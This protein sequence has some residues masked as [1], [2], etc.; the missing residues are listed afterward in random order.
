MGQHEE[1]RRI[2]FSAVK[3]AV[4]LP[5]QAEN[6][7]FNAGDRAAWGRLSLNIGQPLP[8]T[9][10][11]TITRVTGLV[12][13]Q[14]FLRADAGTK[15]AYETA[16]QLSE[17]LDDLQQQF[18][19]TSRPGEVVMTSGVNGPQYQGKRNGYEQYLCSL[20]F[21][22]DYH[23]TA[24]LPEQPTLPVPIEGEDG[25]ILIGEDGSTVVVA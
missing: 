7:P 22:S 4:T 3:A 2:I 25:S 18:P 6:L 11:N 19:A 8:A 10:G 17:A 13:F 12:L 24:P 1:I 15:L 9:V 21:R 20:T 5:Y 23:R 16:G 14:I